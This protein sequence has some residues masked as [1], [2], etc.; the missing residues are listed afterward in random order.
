[1]DRVGLVGTS[2]W[3]AS[4][5]LYDILNPGYI[6]PWIVAISLSRQCRYNGHCNRFY[7]VAEHCWWASY[8]VPEQYAFA[9]L[10][11]DAEEAIV[12]D[13]HKP[14]KVLLGDKYKEISDKV[15]KAISEQFGVYLDREE[16]HVA[17]KRMVFTEKHQLF[18][19]SDVV[20]TDE[21]LYPPYPITLAC[22]DHE[23]AYKKY[24]ERFEELCQFC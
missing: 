5:E 4:G 21:D 10:L 22:W 6:D 2:M 20:L 17:D 24:M 7:S 19:P 9:A 23:T 12:G 16:V 1:M 14:L 3:L 18:P 13:I 11:H 8:H 15:A